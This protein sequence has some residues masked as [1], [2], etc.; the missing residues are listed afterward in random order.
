M[1]R[2]DFL[3]G[4]AAVGA[5][6]PAIGWT[7]FA[8]AATPQRIS[9]PV[10]HENLAVYLVHGP[11]QDGPVPLTLQEALEK[12]AVIVHETG[13]VNRLVIENRGD[14]DVF[15]QAGDIVKG[16]KQD[17]ALTVSMLLPKRTG[18]TPIGASG[19]ERGRWEQRG[20]ENAAR[21]T[22]SDSV[23]PSREAKLAMKAPPPD[24]ILVLTETGRRQSRVWRDVAETQSKLAR[25]VGAPVESPKSRS[26][27]QLSIENERVRTAVAAYVAALAPAADAPDA[28]GFAF[29]I[30]GRINSADL[31]PSHGLFR[32]LWPKLLNAAAT[33]AV[34]EKSAD[35]PAPPSAE[36]VSAFLDRA[37]RGRGGERTLNAQ[38]KLATR[39][40][41]KAY[42]FET[43]RADGAWL[44]RNY[45]AR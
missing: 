36:Q 10:R 42:Y 1:H 9:G 14:A 18:P 32:K 21:F 4:A 23:L 12:K 3:A 45:L 40:T 6:A 7:N 22:S 16:G 27:L 30:N 35:A 31:Y 37:E 8:A 44:H 20:S 28:I 15:V 41:D 26:S 5:A 24:E 43:R 19:I 34:A 11:S 13:D 33:E 17:R 29:A 39:E 38:T 2:R 25:T